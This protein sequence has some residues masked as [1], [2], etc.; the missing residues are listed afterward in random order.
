MIQPFISLSLTSLMLQSL[1]WLLKELSVLWGP[2][3]PSSDDPTER[4]LCA[5]TYLCIADYFFCPSASARVRLLL[6]GPGTGNKEHQIQIFHVDGGPLGRQSLTGNTKVSPW[7]FSDQGCNLWLLCNCLLFFLSSQ[8][9]K[10]TNLFLLPNS[11]I[12]HCTCWIQS[13]RSLNSIFKL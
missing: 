6:F 11:F 13:H 1:S 3:I 9:R 8:K 4:L 5:C 10:L 12:F 2:Q 7:P